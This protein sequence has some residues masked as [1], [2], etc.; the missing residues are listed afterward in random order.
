MKPEN[1]PESQIPA[2]A[3]I[4]RWSPHIWESILPESAGTVKQNIS[5]MSYHNRED[6]GSLNCVEVRH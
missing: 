2:W 3:E 6:R 4:A 5:M 1:S